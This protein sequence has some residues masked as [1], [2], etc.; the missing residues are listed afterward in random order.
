[1]SPL[2]LI[3][4]WLFCASYV[5]PLAQATN[6]GVNAM[7][8]RVG[9][10]SNPGPDNSFWL[11]T[12]NPS[13][14]RGKEAVLIEH[15]IGIH[16]LSETQLSSVTMPTCK[17]TLQHLGKDQ[18]RCIRV[19]SWA[20]A[21]LRAHSTWAGAW[22]GVLSISDWPAREVSIVW[23]DGLYETGR[24][25]VVQHCIPGLPLLVANIY[26]YSPNHPHAAASTDALLAP[27]T[28]EIVLGRIGPRAIV[29]DF[30]AAQDDLSQVSLWK[31]AGWVDIQDLAWQRWASPVQPTCKGATRRDYIFLSPEAAS[32]CVSAYVKDRFQEHSTVG[33]QLRIAPS[34][35]A[36][37]A[38]PLPTEIPW[39][40]IALERYHAQTHAAVP[41]S[42][43]GDSSQSVTTTFFSH[44]ARLF[45]QSLDGNLPVPGG[46]LPGSCRGRAHL[47]TP[48]LQRACVPPPKPSRAGEEALRHDLVPREVHRWFKQLRRLQSLCHALKRSEPHENALEYRGGLWSAIRSAS[49]FHAGFFSWWLHR[50]VQLP[51]CPLRLPEQ[52]PC[53]QVAQAIFCDFRANYRRFEAWHIQKRQQILQNKHDASCKQLYLELREPPSSH[54][55][56]LVSTHTYEVLAR[57]PAEKLLH[58]SAPLATHGHSEWRLDGI[59]VAITPVSQDVCRVLGSDPL[60]TGEELEQ[61]CY[62]SSPPEI[63]E[64]F[65]KVWSERWNKAASPDGW[66]RIFRFTKAFLPRLQCSLE[67]ITPDVWHAALK[68]YKPYAARGPDGYAKTDLQNMPLPRLRELLELLTAIEAGAA[69]PEQ[70]LVG[71]VHALDKRNGKLDVEGYRPIVLFSI[72]YRTWSGI[73]A[74]Q[75]LR[76]LR[77]VISEGALGFLPDHEP[78]EAW[79]VL[80]AN[81]EVAVQGSEPLSG[82]SADLV[83]A[84]NTLPRQPLFAAARWLGIPEG[85]LLPWSNF[86]SGMQRRFV[87]Q[88]CVSAP[89]YSQ[90]GFP[91]GCPL[92][93]VAMCICDFMFHRYLEV[94]TPSIRSL[95][96]VDNLLGTGESAYSVAQGLNATRCFCDAL[97]LTLDGAKTYT[98]STDSIQR[99]ILREL[100]LKVTDAS[101]ELGG[102][103]SFGPSTRNRALVDRCRALGPV[104]RRLS[105]SRAPLHL[106]L[107]TL[108]TKFWS[109]ALHGAAGC[110]VSEATLQGLRTQTVRA[111]KLQCSGSSPMLRL[112]LS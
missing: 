23:P 37:W 83:K 53:Y 68:R 94:F 101:R 41:L 98:W 79:L 27:I 2:S 25:Q 45:E 38:W 67:P 1:M 82:F 3:A 100:R 11:T 14:L 12:S 103:M 15:E 10:A 75:L 64:V 72:V 92:S 51:G 76:W 30:N 65:F 90:C 18:H 32:L 109:M 71:L 5:L 77:D 89:A 57:D 78:A 66:E 7:P 61:S 84:F 47:R 107:R 28:K 36:Y 96:F 111:L 93:T 17:R 63:Q 19:V 62:V 43:D 69:W 70:L 4:C 13:G 74:R 85:V 44:H 56:L 54:V 95:S 34:A 97:G 58:V 31:Q 106:K 35:E 21:P 39:S 55:D 80:Q 112:S 108:P 102:L 87:V 86:L 52:V 60:P 59:P 105:R 16:C 49:G 42:V 8:Y 81:I 22:T 40:E 99:R 24:L 104:F 29:G 48:V 6:C 46:K 73:R 9:E 20:P 26:G 91:E 50:P 33:A 88:H 110:L